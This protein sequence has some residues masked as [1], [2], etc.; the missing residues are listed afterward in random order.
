MAG[1]SMFTLIKVLKDELLLA[2]TT[3][4]S[5]AVLPSLIKRWKTSVVLNRLHRLL[6]QR[7]TRLT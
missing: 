4:S 1:T 2:F 3:A 6:F 7:A 5:E